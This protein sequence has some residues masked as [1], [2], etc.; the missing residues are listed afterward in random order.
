MST[1]SLPEILMVLSQ[2]TIYTISLAE[3]PACEMESRLHRALLKSRQV[4]QWYKEANGSGLPWRFFD[5]AVTLQGLDHFVNR[6]RGNLE[7]TL[8][9]RLR[10]SFPVDLGVVVDE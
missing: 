2:R 6:G 7:I 5:A 8:Q 3:S 9:V 1:A 10:G 4:L